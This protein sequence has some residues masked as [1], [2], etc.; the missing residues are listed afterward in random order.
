MAGRPLAMKRKNKTNLR[1]RW[2]AEKKTNSVPFQLD[3]LARLAGYLAQAGRP[4]MEM[5]SGEAAGRTLARSAGHKEAGGR[6][7]ASL[8][9]HE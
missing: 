8:R 9:A 6:A 2:P 7:K 4:I 1:L 3:L 5:I